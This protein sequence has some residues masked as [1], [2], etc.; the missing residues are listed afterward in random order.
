MVRH[1]DV[2]ALKT[3]LAI[4]NTG[5]FSSAAEALR[6]SQPAISRRIALLEDELEV[7]LFERVPGRTIL[8]QAGRVLVPYAE[9]ALAAMRDA[10]QAVRALATEGAGPI[11]VAVVGTLAGTRL[12]AALTRF[13]RDH[14]KVDLTLRTAT[15]NEVS[16][17]VRVGGAVIGLR[18]WRDRSTDLDHEPL[19]A[20]PL[21]VACAKGHARAGRRA[22]KLTELRSE[23]WLAFPEIPGKREISASH[24]FALFVAHGLGEIDWTPIDSLT[25]QKRLVEAGFGLA[26]LPQSSISEELARGTLDTIRIRDLDASQPIVAVTRR[27]GFLSVAAMRLLDNIRAH[28]AEPDDRRGASRAQPR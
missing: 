3:F 24:I 14:P 17:L 18:Y 12:T 23:R 6:R 11:S 22:A 9:R 27:N 15:S 16:D 4:H 8:S 19:A 10:E 26:L 2:N 5:G 13:G 25:A 20:E 1:M 21:V 28:Y 7:A